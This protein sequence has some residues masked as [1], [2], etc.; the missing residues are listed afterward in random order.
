M[1]NQIIFNSL[2]DDKGEGGFANMDKNILNI[3]N[4]N[5]AKLCRLTSL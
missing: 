2:K 3:I 1:N 4:I 5:V